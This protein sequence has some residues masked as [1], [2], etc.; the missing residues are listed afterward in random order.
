MMIKM[1]DIIAFIERAMEENLN[2]KT[3]IRGGLGEYTINVSKSNGD[4]IT[5]S[6]MDP[7]SLK[8]FTNPWDFVEI[9]VNEIDLALYKV[10]I[11]K[12]GE[13][14]RNKGIEYFN[15]FID[16]KYSGPTTINDLDDEND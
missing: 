12:A 11:L 7:N 13:Y 8:I 10:T 3:W 4:Y 6:Y 14:S 16:K 5:I 15:N 1:D 9:E 2:I